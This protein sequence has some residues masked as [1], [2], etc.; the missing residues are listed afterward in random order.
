MKSRYFLILL[1]A[2]TSCKKE[3]PKTNSTEAAD[4]G[5]EQKAAAAPAGDAKKPTATKADKV[6]AIPAKAPAE[7]VDLP[8]EP[9]VPSENL[10]TVIRKAVLTCPAET[11][12][13]PAY[14][15]LAA[16]IA[17]EIKDAGKLLDSGTDQQKKAIL[18]ALLRSRNTAT[19]ALLVRGLVDSRGMLSPGV[20][21]AIRTLR[22]SDAVKPLEKRLAK[23]QGPEAIPIINTLGHVGGDAAKKVLVSAFDDARLRPFQGEICRAL[24][25]VVETS[26]MAKAQSVVSRTGATER[27]ITGCGGAVAAF[28]V[29]NS[30]GALNLNIDGTRKNVNTVLFYQ[31]ENNP[32][33]IRMAL[34]EAR[35]AGCDKAKSAQ[36]TLEVPLSRT[37]NILTGQG[38][39]SSLSLGKKSLG[40]D[41]LFLHRFDSMELRIGARGK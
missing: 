11:L 9:K 1:L 8:A 6:Q 41:G 32:Y 28:R 21:E 10:L 12:E 39:V 5:A 29:L 22:I 20:I 4:K 25:R 16:K 36:V 40:S 13:C 37:G 3:E 7:R 24:S 2:V 30:S 35:G 33:T 18:A 27:Q 15:A 31:S 23:A 14:D 38:S 26:F 19:D 17:A 34:V